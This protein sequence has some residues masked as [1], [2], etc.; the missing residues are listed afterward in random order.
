M[1]IPIKPR[2]RLR[3]SRS[4]LVISHVTAQHFHAGGYEDIPGCFFS[5]SFLGLHLCLSGSIP[6]GLHPPSTWFSHPRVYSEVLFLVVCVWNVGWIRE[7]LWIVLWWIQ[8]RET[9]DKLVQLVVFLFPAPLFSAFDLY[10]EP[11]DIVVILCL[12]FSRLSDND[13]MSYLQSPFSCLKNILVGEVIPLSLGRWDREQ[14]TSLNRVREQVHSCLNNDRS[15]E[16]VSPVLTYS[17]A[18]LYVY[19]FFRLLSTCGFTFF[20]LQSYPIP[21]AEN[22]CPTTRWRGVVSKRWIPPTLTP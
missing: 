15:E 17:L 7:E 19:F 10:R 3:Q 4:G 8:Q 9:P 5:S 20:L 6:V 18:H 21:S 14:K 12:A 1:L 11:A 2:G 22:I 13:F 16:S